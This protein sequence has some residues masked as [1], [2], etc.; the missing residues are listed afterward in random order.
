MKFFF[1]GT[2]AVVLLG[3]YVYLIMFA[4]LIVECAIHT[5]C[6]DR[7]PSDF[8]Q[9]MSWALTMTTGLVSALVIAELSIT[10]PGTAPLSRVL[11]DDAS[12]TKKL[13]LKVLTFLY[14][15]IWLIAGLFAFM[16]CL[17]H[18]NVLQPLTSVG[19]SWLALALGATYAW[20]GI[21]PK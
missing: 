10:K 11:P 19:E 8:N 7:V 14:I 16:K 13:I 6:T 3:I 20:L 4:Y 12:E 17:H 9:F 5:G 2:I 1:G 18:P 15:L 21:K